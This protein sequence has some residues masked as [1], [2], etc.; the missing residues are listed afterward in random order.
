MLFALVLSLN[1]ALGL[2]H[3]DEV[4]RGCLRRSV[5]GNQLIYFFLD[6][7]LL[8]NQRRPLLEEFIVQP[9]NVVDLLNRNIFEVLLDLLILPANLFDVF[10]EQLEILLQLF[11]G[12]LETET[13]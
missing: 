7:S 10:V 9:E 2:D 6:Y 13:Q 1:Q 5:L 4:H 12:F 8:W 11:L 3:G